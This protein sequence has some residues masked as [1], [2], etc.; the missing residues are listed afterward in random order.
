MRLTQHQIDVLKRSAAD[1]FGPAT[2]LY[3]FGSRADDRSAGGDIDLFVTGYDQSGDRR[4]DAKLRFLVRVKKEIG[5]Q[6]IDLVFA[7]L[8]GQSPLPIH[9]IAE[10]TGV[11]L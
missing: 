4:L 11:E 9:R 7:P 6:R 2:R 8:P 10:K 1:V 3:L 5:E